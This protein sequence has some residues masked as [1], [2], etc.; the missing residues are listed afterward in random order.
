MQHE[1]L[2]NNRI[3]QFHIITWDWRH[4]TH[5][6]SIISMK[7]PQQLY[8]SISATNVFLK[9]AIINVLSK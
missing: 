2:S 6:K 9:F 8:M 1:Q 4:K 5:S 3:T 7:M